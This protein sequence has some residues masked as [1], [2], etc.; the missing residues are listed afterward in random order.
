MTNSVMNRQSATPSMAGSG[1]RGSDCGCPD[2]AISRRRLLQTAAATTGALAGATMFGDTFRQVAYGAP[3][4]NVVVVLS[5]RGGADGLSIVVPKGADH[6]VLAA[7]RP[8]VVI[9]EDQLIG[10]DANFGLHPALAPLLP[11]WTAGKF[12]AVHGIGL[13]QPNRS[14]FDATAAVEDADPGSVE[15]RGW[16]N[17][18][19]GLNAGALPE[20]HMHLG[21]SMLQLQ[22]SGPAP[23]LAAYSINALTLPNLWP[24]KRLDRAVKQAWRGSSKLDVAVRQAV[25]CTG[26]LR[27]LAATDPAE[28]ATVTYPEGPLRDVLLNT[29]ALIKGDVGARV[30]TIDYGDWDM[31]TGMGTVGNGWMK[32]HLT[33]LAGSLKAFFDDLGP[34]GDR[35]TLFTISEFGRRV[36]QNGDNGTDHGY[37][38]AMLA[39][40]AGVNGGAVRGQWRHLDNLND[41]DVSLAQDYRSVIWEVLS[42]R[43][44]EIS[45][46]RASVFPGF[47]PE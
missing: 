21:G 7:A 17:R 14:H 9:P 25:D 22:L 47:T 4:G 31:H 46:K 28:V 39:F 42:K 15:R 13:P 29:A 43:F 44:P 24:D 10:G 35:V 20:E 18:L 16:I 27:T 19:I 38:N 41:G 23:A 8:G 32:D 1:Q 36:E 5:L 2:Y 11:M 3:G 45:G 26:R 33:H 37:G 40:G 12:G 6:D 30:V 34:I